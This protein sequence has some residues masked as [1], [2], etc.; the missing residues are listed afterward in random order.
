MTHNPIEQNI[1]ADFYTAVCAYVRGEPNGIVAGTVGEEQ[2]EIAKQ[3]FQDNP[4]I[5]DDMDRLFAE[6]ARVHNPKVD[7]DRISRAEY[8]RRMEE[9]RAAGLLIDPSTAELYW[10]YGE[11]LDPYGDGL[12]L[13][14]LEQQVGREYFARAPDSDIWVNVRDLPKATRAAIWER[15]E[16]RARS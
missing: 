10:S 13:L 5:L 14:P 6:I 8:D 1:N 4:A 3:L 16:K 9:R 7:R 15:F 2:A 12:D 11:T